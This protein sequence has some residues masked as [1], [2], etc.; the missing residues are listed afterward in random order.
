MPGIHKWKTLSFRPSESER[1]LIEARAKVSGMHKKDF[2]TKS[3]IYSTVC[4]VGNK[5]HIESLVLA[6]Q[7]LRFT[8]RDIASGMTTGNF[9]VSNEE[10]A[11]MRMEYIS[12]VSSLMEII[13]AAAY[14]F[15]VV[16]PQENEVDK[17]KAQILDMVNAIYSKTEK[18]CHQ[19]PEVSKP[20]Q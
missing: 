3:C 8:L 20:C 6:V 1:Q 7:D 12:F 11:E 13:N 17:Q 10:F 5:K 9:E 2:I 14:L 4:V 16:V 18:T 19:E 15:D